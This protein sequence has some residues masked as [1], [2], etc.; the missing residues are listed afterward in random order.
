MINVRAA[1]DSR[2]VRAG[3]DGAFYDDD[4]ELLATCESY[5]SNVTF[6]NN[7][8]SVLGNAQELEGPGT[9]SVKLTMSQI[10]IESD[11]FIQM[12][13]D[14]ME[15]QQP[16]VLN[17]QGVLTGNNGSEER[18]IYRNCITSGQIDLQNIGVGDAVK[19]SWNFHV[20]TPP[21][22]QSLLTISD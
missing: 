10:V 4:G 22:L 14:A 1:K 13:Y 6:N 16:L 5:N 20:N 21:K 17:F 11:K 12:V 18:V 8:Y 19:R 3:K 2:H 9:F 15:N 7:Q